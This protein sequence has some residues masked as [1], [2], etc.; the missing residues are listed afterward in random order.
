[1]EQCTPSLRGSYASAVRGEQPATEEKHF[2]P[3]VK[4]KQNE[5]PE[6]VTVLLKKNVNPMQLKIGIRS[7]KSI[8]DGRIVI[9]F[10]SKEEINLLSKK[11]TEKCSQVLEVETP[12]YGNLV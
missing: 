5:S 3:F 6:A 9:E 7:M 11:I 1:M 8:K 10:G 2:K 12:K 4:S